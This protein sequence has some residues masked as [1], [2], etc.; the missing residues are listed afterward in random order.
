MSVT[1]PAS[2]ALGRPHGPAAVVCGVHPNR[3]YVILTCVSSPTHP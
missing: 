2:T 1:A 3:A